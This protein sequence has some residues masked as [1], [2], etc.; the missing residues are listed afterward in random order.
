MIV[1]ALMVAAVAGVP[2]SA[3]ADYDLK[4]PG[5][6][7]W[8]GQLHIHTNWVPPDEMAKWYKYHGYNFINF[9]DVNKAEAGVTLNGLYG[10][11]NFFVMQGSELSVY[12]STGVYYD[13]CGLG[14]DQV[15]AMK[16]WMKVMD[17]YRTGKTAVESLNTQGK[18]IYETGGFPL[19]NHPNF[20]WAFGSKELLATDPKL[21]RHFELYNA[22]HG[23]NNEGGNGRESTEEMWDKVLS[24]GRLL[25]GH[26]VDDSHHIEHG[27]QHFFYATS[28][29]NTP[30]HVWQA[31]ALVGR[32]STFVLADGPLTAESVQRALQNGQFYSVQHLVN[33]PIRLLQYDVRKDGIELLLPQRNADKGNHAPQINHTA[34]K[35]HFI[36]KDGKVLKVDESYNPQYKFKG[37]ELYVRVKIVDSDG[38]VAWLQPIF[39]KTHD[40]TRKF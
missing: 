35:T 8:R 33:V 3:Q 18:I 12:T 30:G 24:T 19:V 13:T 27:E 38:G 15:A 34:Y 14:G 37:D 25:Y 5:V 29:E 16:A 11:S 21:I 40:F 4:A 17:S 6:K 28:I 39:P 31:K 9:T 32:T 7:W 10:D 36:G 20:G 1:I 2:N 22:E 23:M 26:A